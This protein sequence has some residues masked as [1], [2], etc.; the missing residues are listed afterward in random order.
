MDMPFAS[1]SLDAVICQFGVMLFPDSA[2]AF[3]EAARVL[4]HGGVFL[5]NVWDC[6]AA[7]EFADA[8]TRA[9]AAPFP[10]D[11]PMFP[12]RTPHGYYGEPVI[13]GD[14]SAADLMCHQLRTWTRAASLLPA[15]SRRSHIA[16]AQRY[17]TK[18]RIAT[19]T[20]W[21]RPPMRRH[22]Q[23]PQGTATVRSTV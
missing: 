22:P 6:L 10:D 16:R 13:T 20:G 9:M 11:P 19:H 4:R 5:F 15:R 3:A 12:D 7:N 23:S 18:S 1:E 21:A 14:L 8:V 17:A 2:A